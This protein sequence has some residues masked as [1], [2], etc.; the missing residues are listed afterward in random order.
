MQIGVRG[1]ICHELAMK[2]F[3][4]SRYTKYHIRN[5]S[6]FTLLEILV[7]TSIFAVLGILITRSVLLTLGAGQKSQTLVSVRENLNYAASVIETQLRNANSILSSDCTGGT[8][9]IIH[10]TDQN[11]ASASFSC[12]NIGGNAGYIASGSS[13]LTNNSV[14]VTNCSFVCNPG[15]AGTPDS[16]NIKLQAQDASASGTENSIVTVSTQVSLRNY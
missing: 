11:S 5:T 12:V 2:K 10:Y 16:I 15:L 14:N 9:S 4:F 3:L 6:A 1:S 7:V 13:Q 8:L